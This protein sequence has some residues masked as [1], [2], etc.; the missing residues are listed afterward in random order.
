MNNSF[1]L[2]SDSFL[3]KY[4]EDQFIDNYKNKPSSIKS[5]NRKEVKYSKIDRYDGSYDYEKYH[6]I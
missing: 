1:C 3:S 2:F 4:F 6:T 5:W